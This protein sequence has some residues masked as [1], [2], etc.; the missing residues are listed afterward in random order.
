MQVQRCIVTLWLLLC[1]WGCG[2][3]NSSNDDA[4]PVIVLPDAATERDASVDAAA[5]MDAG[6]TFATWEPIETPDELARW[7]A[8]VIPVGDGRFYL[9]G[10]VRVSGGNLSATSDLM[11][12]DTRGEVLEISEVATTNSPPARSRTC[13]AFDPV[14]GRLI[15]R[16]GRANGSMLNDGVTWALDVA[17]SAWTQL[18]TEGPPGLVGC[19]MAFVAEDRAMYHFGG[20]SGSGWSNELW[21]FDLETDQWYAVSVEGTSPP[22]GYDM[23]LA[24]RE[25]T[26]LLFGGGVGVG[27]DGIF[28]SDVFTFDVASARWSLLEASGPRPEGRRGHWMLLSDDGQ[29][30]LIGGGEGAETSLEDL[31]LFDRERATWQDLTPAGDIPRGRGTFATALP[32]PGD[33]TI[34]VFS[35]ITAPVGNPSEEGWKLELMNISF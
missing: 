7:G 20:G 18:D 17:T 34:T 2:G 24:V 14:D 16:G 31:W 27:G 19:A 29:R 21:R 11:I 32:G 8:T 30:I 9:F 35:G 5:P 4:G 6:T 25:G 1:V 10:G 13:A 23:T 12:V 28:G 3:A 15:V 26:L 33:A 22:P